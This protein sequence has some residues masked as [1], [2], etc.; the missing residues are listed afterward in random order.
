MK[1]LS[2]NFGTIQSDAGLSNVGLNSKPSYFII[3][4]LPYIFGAAGIVLILNI[5]TAGLK[6]MTSKGD[7]KAL[8]GAQAKLTTSAVGILILFVSFWFVQIIMKFF[9][10]NFGGG[11]IIQ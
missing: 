2:Q 3:I 5:V 8:Q 6:I 10:I 7:P 9:G 4:A 11:N 1:L